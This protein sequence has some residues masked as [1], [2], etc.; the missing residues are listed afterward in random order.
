[1]KGVVN[2]GNLW[3]RLIYFILLLE[4]LVNFVEIC[5]FFI[6]EMFGKCIWI[7]MNLS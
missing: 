1:M 5:L 3:E 7:R 4:F 6:L 2:V